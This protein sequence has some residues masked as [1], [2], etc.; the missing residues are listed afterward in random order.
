MTDIATTHAK[1]LFTSSPFSMTLA[2]TLPS[3]HFYRSATRFVCSAMHIN[4]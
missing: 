2:V 3:L 4:G 1:K